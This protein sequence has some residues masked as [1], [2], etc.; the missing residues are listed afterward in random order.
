MSGRSRFLVGCGFGLA[1]TL[2]GVALVAASR[3]ALRPEKSGSSLQL[4]PTKAY[5]QTEV[6]APREVEMDRRVWPGTRL[7]PPV[8]NH[9][10]Q[11]LHQGISHSLQLVDGTSIASVSATG[12]QPDARLPRYRRSKAMRWTRAGSALLAVVAAVSLGF[13]LHEH[14][15]TSNGGGTQSSAVTPAE[16]QGM[17]SDRRA[18]VGLTDVVAQPL[19]A[20]GGGFRIKLQN[21]GNTPAL[22]LQI[23]AEVAIARDDQRINLHEPDSPARSLAG[24]LRPGAVYAT[25]IDFRTSPEGISSLAN[26]QLRAVSFIHITYKDV[27]QRLHTTKACF[28]WQRSLPGVK[29]CDGYNELN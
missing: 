22:D 29:P 10:P 6:C 3:R 19:T 11:I 4:A 12:G 7:L 9:P 26:D 2:A 20:E 5:G 13:S 14:R 24:T 28:Y 23:A 1:T 15:K 16:F 21:A 27:F 17:L 18:W 8:T 25:D